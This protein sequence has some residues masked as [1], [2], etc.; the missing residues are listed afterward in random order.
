M[1]KNI[2]KKYIHKEIDLQPHMNID[3]D[4][5]QGIELNACTILSMITEKNTELKSCFFTINGFDFQVCNYELY[6]YDQK[7]DE[8]L[9]GDVC[10]DLI[11]RIGIMKCLRKD[12]LKPND[13]VRQN[14]N[15]GIV[16]KA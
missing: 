11:T 2:E 7:V 3:C 14:G 8:K 6:L 1:K 10:N 15:Q 12:G 4:T 9:F 5:I 13:V 16:S